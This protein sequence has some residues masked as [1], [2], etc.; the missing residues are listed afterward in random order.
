VMG[1][2]AKGDVEIGII[3]MPFIVFETGADLVGPLP[4]ELQDYVVYAAGLS[5]ASKSP[6]AAA[7]LI[8]YVTSPA[9]ASA[10]KS[11]GLDPIAR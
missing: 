10:F 1:P 9:A 8:Q 3:T 11:H 6:D 4:D 5:A 2:V 7:A